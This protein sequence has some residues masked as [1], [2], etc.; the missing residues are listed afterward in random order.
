MKPNL[1]KIDVWFEPEIVLEIKAADLQ[2]SPVH[3]C[4][5]ADLDNSIKYFNLIFR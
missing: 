1:K 2:I 4:G 5:Y 3:S